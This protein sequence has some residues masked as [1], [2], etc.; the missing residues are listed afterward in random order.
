MNLVKY[1]KVK[2]K[3]EH[4]CDFCGEIIEKGEEHYYSFVVDGKDNWPWRS[5]ERCEDIAHTLQM[6]RYCNEEGLTSEAFKDSIDDYCQ[7]NLKINDDELFNMTY[8][9]KIIAIKKIY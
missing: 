3:E 9:E 7:Y 5:H 4:K 6:Y 2:A 8:K 1:K